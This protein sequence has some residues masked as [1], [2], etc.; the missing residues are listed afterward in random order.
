MNNIEKDLIYT[1]KI[2]NGDEV[3]TKVVDIDEDGNYIVS[4][5]LTVVPGPQGIQ[6]IMSLFTANPDKNYQLNKSQCSMIALSRDEVRDSY[7]EATTGIKP[8]TNK[9]LMG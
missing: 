3:V 8:V 7:I 5:P 4:K 1:I 6:M 2:A 9:I